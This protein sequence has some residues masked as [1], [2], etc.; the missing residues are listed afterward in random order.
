VSGAKKPRVRK[1]SRVSRAVLDASALLAVMFKERGAENV[2]ARL[3]GSMVSAVNLSE[4]VTKSVDAGMTLEEARLVASAFPCEIIPFEGELAYLAASLRTATRA[5]GVSM[6]D[7]ACL[8]LGLNTGHPVVTADRQWDK[9]NV[10][11]KV[12]QIR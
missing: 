3:P 6:A 2:I 1:K 9:F 5:F 4:T 11:V 8:A 7:R 10:G 12:I